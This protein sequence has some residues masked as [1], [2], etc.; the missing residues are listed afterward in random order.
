[1]AKDIIE[2][3]IFFFLKFGNLLVIYECQIKII[4]LNE[5]KYLC[6]NN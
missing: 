4:Y 2:L 1:M 5:S 3:I 6:D